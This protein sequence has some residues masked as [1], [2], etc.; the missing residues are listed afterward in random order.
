MGEAKKAEHPKS[1]SAAPSFV[2]T[3][4]DGEEGEE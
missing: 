1:M 4:Q 2:K 3:S